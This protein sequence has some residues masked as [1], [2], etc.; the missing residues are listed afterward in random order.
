MERFFSINK[1]TLNNNKNQILCVYI[2]YVIFVFE[3]AFALILN[4]KILISINI[5]GSKRIK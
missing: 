4:S 3:I 1:E 2:I 5:L